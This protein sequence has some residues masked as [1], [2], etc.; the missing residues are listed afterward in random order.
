MELEIA[1]LTKN[2]PIF[3]ENVSSSGDHVMEADQSDARSEK[4]EQ[5]S[6]CSDDENEEEFDPVAERVC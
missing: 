2:M 3:N 5:K 6:Q 1:V 4:S